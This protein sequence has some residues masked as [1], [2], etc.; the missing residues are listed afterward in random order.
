MNPINT[1]RCQTTKIVYV[2]FDHHSSYPL[3]THVTLDGTMNPYFKSI[4]ENKL[5][6]NFLS[7]IFKTQKIYV[8]RMA[9]VAHDYNKVILKYAS[10]SFIL[11]IK[12]KLRDNV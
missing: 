1:L 10:G 11:K 5:Y 8:K 9:G 2:P 4:K 6:Q 12:N 3:I 7:I